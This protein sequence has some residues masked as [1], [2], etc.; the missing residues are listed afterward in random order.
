[1]RAR[2]RPPNCRRDYAA[3]T[4]FAVTVEIAC[5]FLRSYP[6]PYLLL[7]TTCFTSPPLIV[8]ELKKPDV[9][10]KAQALQKLC[11]VRP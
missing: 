11:Y 9:T 7:V 5:D 1:M 2:A 10:I 4:D 8:Q 6:R 3:A